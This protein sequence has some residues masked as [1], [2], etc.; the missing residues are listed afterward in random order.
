MA[1]GAHHGAGFETDGGERGLR[2]EGVDADG[3]GEREGDVK[4]GGD[5]GEQRQNEERVEAL[6]VGGGG[7]PSEQAAEQG[8][9]PQE[10]PP[11]HQGPAVDVGAQQRRRVSVRSGERPPHH[12]LKAFHERHCERQGENPPVCGNFVSK[13]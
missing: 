6:G 3:G 10:D 4:E 2:Q 1:V 8:L 13:K 9:R 7:F 5:Q 12:S 11:N